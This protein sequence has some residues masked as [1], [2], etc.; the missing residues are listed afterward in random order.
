MAGSVFSLALWQDW[1][2]RWAPLFLDASLKGVFILV[3]AFAVTLAMRRTTSAARQLVWFYA[4]ASLLALPALALI[5]PGW[6]I[7]PA[8]T[9]LDAS[10]T[11]VVRAEDPSSKPSKAPGLDEMKWTET[12]VNPLAEPLSLP[13][14]AS[15][16][17]AAIPTIVPEAMDKFAD[18]TPRSDSSANKAISA[19]GQR[20]LSAVFNSAS[21]MT[22]W[23][24]GVM[25]CLTPLAL[26]HISLWRLKRRTRRI[27]SGEGFLLLEK[28]VAELGFK[29]PVILLESDRRTMPMMWGISQVYLL[30]PQEAREWP[31]QRL[32]A[33]FL[34]ELAH[35][36]RWD[37]LMKFIAH[38]ACAAYWFNP[39]V[40]LAFRRLQIESEQACDDLVLASGCQPSEYAEDILRIASGLQADFFSAHS[41]IAMARKSKLEGRL[42]AVLDQSRK[43]GKL[44][45][46]GALLAGLLCAGLV[47]PMAILKA[48]SAGE[49]AGGAKKS[50]PQEAA[51]CFLYIRHNEVN[52][53]AKTDTLVLGKISPGSFEQKDICT[54]GDLT[55]GFEL[56]GVWNGAAYA[57]RFNDLLC[58]ELETGQCV[59][60]AS[61][62]KFHA[63]ADGRL[64][65]L[66]G[67]SAIREYDFRSQCFRD[68]ALPSG[69]L[70][71]L[72]DSISP[73][74]VAPD[75]RHLAFFKSENDPSSPNS[76]SVLDQLMIVDLEA[77]DLKP[78]GAPVY[79]QPPPFSCVAPDDGPPLVWLDEKTLAF[80]RTEEPQKTPDETSVSVMLDVEDKTIYYLS[81]ANI[82]SGKVRDFAPIPGESLTMW[83]HL[84]EPKSFAPAVLTLDAGSPKEISYAVDLK[85]G[86]LMETD[87]IGKQ[88]ALRRQGK[89]QQLYASGKKLFEIERYIYAAISPD[90]RRALYTG[91]FPA[92]RLYC[93]DEQNGARHVADGWFTEHLMWVAD[94]AIK[95]LPSAPQP[96]AGWTPFERLPYPEP[97]PKDTRKDIS[98]Y[99]SFSITTDKPVYQLNEA[100]LLTFTVTNKS[101][102]TFEIAP[103]PPDWRI[104]QITLT[105]PGGQKF[106]ARFWG[107]DQI[108]PIKMAALKGG[109]SISTTHVLELSAP[110][111]YK[112]QGSL[113]MH[114]PGF[115]SPV[116][117]RGYPKAA[118]ISFTVEASSDEERLFKIKFERLLQTLR[119]QQAKG[120]EWNGWLPAVDDITDMGKPASPFLMDAI[121]KEKNPL[122]ARRL[123]W[124]LTRIA[125]PAALSCYREMAAKGDPELGGDAINGLYE[126]YSRNTPARSGAL[127][128][129][130][131][132]AARKDS[133][134]LRKAAA[135]VLIR[136]HEPSVKAAFEK[137]VAADDSLL[138]G[139]AARY[140][141]AD[142]NM[143]LAEWL[144]AAAQNLTHARF[145]AA[146]VIISDLIKTQHIT[147]KKD[148]SGLEW[149]D[150][151][152]NAGKMTEARQAILEWEKWARENPRASSAYFDRDR[153][154]WGDRRAETGNKEADSRSALAAASSQANPSKSSFDSLKVRISSTWAW[155][156]T[157]SI[158]SDGTY[159]FDMEQLEKV[160]GEKFMRPAAKHYIA[161]YRI[162]PEHQRRLGELLEAT[163]YLAQSGKSEMTMTDGTKFDLTLMRDGRETKTSCYG[164]Q[165]ERYKALLQFLERVNRQEWLLY[166]A[167][168]KEERLAV[169]RD[170]GNELDALK[171]KPV[172]MPYAPILDYHRLVP[173]FSESLANPVERK[174]DEI[175]GAA[176]LM[177]FLKLESQ[178][179]NL[180][181]VARG[182]VS[183]ADGHTSGSIPSEARLAAA[184]ALAQIGAEASLDTLRSI[185]EDSDPFLRN[186]IAEAVFTLP[187]E[188]AIPMLAEMTT[189][190]Q[191]AAWALIRL[192]A[193]AVPAILD[194]LQ[195]DEAEAVRDIRKG[196]YYLIRAYYDHWKEIPQ[197][198]NPDIL[199]AIRT[200][201]EFR[202]GGGHSDVDYGLKV[203][204]L[205]GQPF[206]PLNARQ[207]LE[208]FLKTAAS[209]DAKALE[210]LMS[211]HF[212]NNDT[213]KFLERAKAGQIRVMNV[214]AD[215]NS[216]WARA[217]DAENENQQYMIW[218]NFLGGR[219]WEIAA[220]VPRSRAQ[221]D[222]EFQR[223]MKEHP[224][225]KELPL[226]D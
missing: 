100:A 54:E 56:L 163:Q 118:P 136:I 183:G 209:Q 174:T 63:F 202:G 19:S 216:A 135:N 130:L 102:E 69:A 205:A 151:S 61:K 162:G 10:S 27:A 181:A 87:A 59:R 138:A 88:F 50:L 224:D 215:K 191:N 81:I 90:Q 3:A 39:L 77:R 210:R 94:E 51:N 194:I 98:D 148:L 70:T 141:A 36:K 75:A 107:S 195:Y 35:A 13:A 4:L 177:G 171:G 57:R 159:Q 85:A 156:R 160:P 196:P 206:K 143:N 11:V 108:N 126:L 164:D 192:G 72:C 153:E 37:C 123:L 200:R 131:E 96:R 124:S 42:L 197:P 46:I 145:L 114:G 30:L 165:E 7:L 78:L 95:P 60:I 40:W 186:A 150:V 66:W 1:A 170:L 53:T 17:R 21:L 128:A 213:T 97:T 190:S 24:L 31:S 5:L 207:T 113:R 115:K 83:L 58:F 73:W 111:A 84:R 44:T 204:E 193:P 188:K 179:K 222:A 86:K 52:G 217:A 101:N 219:V 137:I 158:K 172:V 185:R 201:I 187:P 129:L 144:A 182:G 67:E 166:Q 16:T 34:H 168:V 14:Q 127:E 26:G 218:M 74:G 214:C 225:V 23:L 147:D 2:S 140:L 161:E 154:L 64:F 117:L 176:K 173:A 110:G 89:F 92:R 157:I 119:E 38:L 12:P 221:I 28:A 93:F 99:L 41:G 180:E 80:V 45:F 178:R 8:W 71:G 121:A 112:I 15:E 76:G 226:N 103:P 49:E 184:A 223:I 43:R 208:S 167:T 32:Y 155:N 47:A 29:R 6:R 211:M 104:A 106:L 220:A 142:E 9:R 152:E 91:G 149:K 169:A 125:D 175:I 116:D 146:R 55:A 120:P 134:P 203:L 22:L 199:G 189:Q 198:V 105:Y 212:G 68:I 109:Q 33:V 132:I 25:A 82:A 139:R 48:Q 65:C 20:L 18:K 122:I 79:Y 133:Q 62:I